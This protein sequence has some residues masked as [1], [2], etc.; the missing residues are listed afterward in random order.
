MKNDVR[1]EHVEGGTIAMNR[2]GDHP[3][4]FRFQLSDANFILT[5]TYT[6]RNK[7]NTKM[8]IYGSICL[9]YMYLYIYNK[10]MDRRTHMCRP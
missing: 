7:S 3:F 2:T 1:I 4:H 9:G 5:H 10:P 8:L 6:H